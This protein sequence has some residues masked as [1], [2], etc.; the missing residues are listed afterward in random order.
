MSLWRCDRSTANDDVAQSKRSAW[1]QGVLM[2]SGVSEMP[3]FAG[4]DGGVIALTRSRES[5]FG[6]R[7]STSRPGRRFL[8]GRGGH[9]EATDSQIID[10]N[11]PRDDWRADPL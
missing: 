10:G 4:V 9:Q 2:S 8:R 7:T 6:S 1:R 11:W 5:F 3:G